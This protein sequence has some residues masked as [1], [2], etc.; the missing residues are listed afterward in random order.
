MKSL[1][2]LIRAPEVNWTEVNN[3]E[4]RR[5]TATMIANIRSNLKS[6]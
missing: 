6:R 1:L 2:S 5:N 4:A 3:R